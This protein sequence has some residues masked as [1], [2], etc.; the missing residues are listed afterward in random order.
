MKRKL[1]I[2]VYYDRYHNR[3]TTTIKA[4]SKTDAETKFYKQNSYPFYLVTDV[5]E[6][7]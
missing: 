1:F 3:H 2:I 5:L 6:K 7:Q 4:K